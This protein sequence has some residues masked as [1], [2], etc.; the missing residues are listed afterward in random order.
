MRV[1][2]FLFKI[3]FAPVS[4]Y[5]EKGKLIASLWLAVPVSFVLLGGFNILFYNLRPVID[6]QMASPNH[7]VFAILIIVFV[8]Y[9]L[10]RVYVK[11][12]RNIGESYPALTGLLIPLLVIG[13]LILFVMTLKYS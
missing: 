12:K 10:E 5:K 11:H 2:D 9:S 6:I 1:L 8:S 3:C 13:S 4:A 7:F